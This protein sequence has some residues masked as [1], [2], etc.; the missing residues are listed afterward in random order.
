MKR[1]VWH[2]DAAFAVIMVALMGAAYF[3]DGPRDPSNSIKPITT[4]TDDDKRL[5]CV[6]GQPPVDW[7]CPDGT[8]L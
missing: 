2:I 7:L 1:R 8:R 3:F 5:L 4:R 6:D